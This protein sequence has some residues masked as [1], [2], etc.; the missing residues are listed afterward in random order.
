MMFFL[1]PIVNKKE[2]LKLETP[3]NRA[4]TILSKP[5]ILNLRDKPTMWH[6]RA[7]GISLMAKRNEKRK[8]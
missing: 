2:N 8:M 5:L 3:Y 4:T 7:F 6:S 1:C